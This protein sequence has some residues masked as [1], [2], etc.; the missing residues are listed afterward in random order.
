VTGLYLATNTTRTGL[1]ISTV[2]NGALFFATDTGILWKVESGSW[3]NK[4]TRLDVTTDYKVNGVKVV[5]AQ[6]SAIPDAS[7][8][9][10]I[11]AEART[12]INGLLAALRTHGM[13]HT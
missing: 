4:F 6:S 3:A 12:A 5:G 13:I 2:D 11:D 7:G 10:T 9:V 1:T 8:G